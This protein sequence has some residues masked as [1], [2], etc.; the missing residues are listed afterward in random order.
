AGENVFFAA[1]GIT[2][3]ELLQGVRFLGRGLVSTHSVV[4]HSYSGTVRYIETTHD[5]ARLH[6]RPAAVSE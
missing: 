3:G 6:A 1:T 5:L 2:T 4:L